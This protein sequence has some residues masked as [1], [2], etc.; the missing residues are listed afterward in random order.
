MYQAYKYLEYTH[1][2]THTLHSTFIEV[3]G[4][5]GPSQHGLETSVILTGQNGL[6]QMLVKHTWPYHLL[7]END[8]QVHMEDNIRYFIVQYLASVSGLYGHLSQ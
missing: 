2:H 6:D 7:A 5:H 8:L 1:T 3:I 4:T